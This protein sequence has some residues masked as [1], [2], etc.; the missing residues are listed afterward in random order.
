LTSIRR[1]IERVAV[2]VALCA[3]ALPLC[4]GGAA[5]GGAPRDASA[6]VQA[7]CPAA[8]PGTAECLVLTRTDVS[9]PAGTGS[10][11]SPAVA[12]AGYG[13]A[14]LLSAYGLP[15][16][17]AGSGLTVAVIDAYDL[18]W[19]ES[20]L[21]VYRAAYGLPACTTANGCFRKVDQRGGTSYPAYSQGWGAEIDLDIDMVSA[22]CPNCNI[23]LVEADN[24]QMA[25]LAQAVETA[26]SMGAI[27]VSNSYSGPEFGNES[28]FDP[29][30]SHPGVAIT[31][32]TGD[33]GY[34]CAGSVAG[35]V[36]YPAASAGV[37]AVGGTSLIRDSSVRG[38]AETAWSLGG[39][40][41]SLYEAKPSWQTDPGCSN[42]T[43]ADVSAVADPNTPVATYASHYYSNGWGMAGGTSVGAPIVAAT[44]A[45]AGGL[46]P[47]TNPASYLY[48]DPAD[49]YD[50]VS[51]NNNPYGLP[52]PS[53]YSAYLCNAVTGYDGPTGLGTPH[54]VNAFK[55]AS[56]NAPASYHPLNPPL[57]YVDTR[58]GN[59]L[60]G[61]LVANTPASFYVTAAGRPSSPGSTSAPNPIPA[62]ASAVTGNLTVTGSTFSWAVYL[63]PNPVA[64]PGSSTINFTAGETTANGVTVALSSSGMLSATYLSTPGNT[65][66]LVFDVTGYFTPDATGATYSA[67]TPVRLLDTRFG[68]GLGGKLLANT[69]A[70]FFVTAANRAGSPVPASAVAVT[71]N[72]TVVNETF[73]WAVYAGPVA[74]A[75]PTTSTLNFNTGDIKA[76][77][78]TVTLGAGGSLWLTYMS[79]PGNTTDLVFDV[80]GYYTADT[81]GSMFVPVT[82]TRLLDNR[83]T[84]TPAGVP[85]KLLA[86]TPFYL[87]VSVAGHPGSPVPSNA[88]AVTGNVTITNPSFAW[89]IYCGDVSNAAPTTSTLNFTTGQTK[90]NGVTVALDDG[91]I[92][93]AGYRGDLW[94]TYLSTSGNTTDLVFDVTGYFVHVV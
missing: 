55:T 61:S 73:A 3:L 8:K 39:S 60:S 9:A 11:A 7:A 49:L 47:G 66:D 13:P 57:R 28:I 89:A 37:V 77:N 64:H 36:G 12:S 31:V 38:W 82:P 41:C 43:Q 26:V 85:G 35:S 30:Y 10:G 70:Q 34:D 46:G 54:G 88:S 23:L 79:T 18:P 91:S 1:V 67:L 29:Y 93:G 2:A 59:G 42:R 92:D 44:F 15:G 65:T 68:N 4:G 14:D 21:G 72:L 22:I 32:S 20:D 87:P 17:S 16:G 69:P 33:C 78:L 86:N 51:G 24:E 27:A 74:N 50:V 19:A 83:T 71:G 94:F 40:G 63:G 52:C 48:A 5:L 81:T 76:N 84:N 58:T 45:L 75:A 56:A 25:S 90:A 80:T 62:D 53:A 6:N